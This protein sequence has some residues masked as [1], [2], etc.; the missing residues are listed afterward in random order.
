MSDV[1]VIKDLNK[2]L[3]IEY[4]AS[5]SVEKVWEAYATKDAFERWWG[6]EGW[7]TTTKEFNFVSGGRIH[8]GMKC[9]SE[10]QSDW[11]DQIFVGANGHS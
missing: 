8:Y 7:D 9:V 3:I 11:F 1:K 10:N 6:P 5:G 2:T 4:V